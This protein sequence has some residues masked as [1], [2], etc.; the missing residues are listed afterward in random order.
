MKNKK[1]KKILSSIESKTGVDFKIYQSDELNDKIADVII[2]PADLVIRLIKYVTLYNCMLFVFFGSFYI[3]DTSFWQI[4]LISAIACCILSITGFFA[5]VV[6]VITSFTGGLSGIFNEISGI[7]KSLARDLFLSGVKCNLGDVNVDLKERYGINPLETNEKM[8]I[9]P[10]MQ[11]FQGVLLAVVYPAI[12]S[13]IK[14]RYGFLE[15][16]IDPTVV[17]AIMSIIN[18][19]K[20]F[21]KTADDMINKTFSVLNDGKIDALVDG[22]GDGLSDIQKKIDS[23]IDGL[24]PKLELAINNSGKIAAKPF[25]LARNFST[26]LLVLLFL[27][28]LLQS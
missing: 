16:L 10:V 2:S 21:L 27:V 4:L 20:P 9:P 14:K 11:I 25:I 26:A 15:R 6:S 19:S 5:A 23:I 8:L 22:V 17:L 18:V 1:I 7:I 13:V 3:L 12:N 24:T 28:H